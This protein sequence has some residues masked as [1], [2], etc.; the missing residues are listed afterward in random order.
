MH[1]SATVGAGL[2]YML[3]DRLALRGEYLYSRSIRSVST[4]LDSETC[5]SQ[6]REGQSVRFGLGYFLR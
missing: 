5:C 4:K 6:K 1:T 3:T 2:E